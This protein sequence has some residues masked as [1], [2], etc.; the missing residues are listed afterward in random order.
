MVSLVAKIEYCIIN[1]NWM[2]EILAGQKKTLRYSEV[3]PWFPKY[4]IGWIGIGKC[5]QETPNIYECTSVSRPFPII[6]FCWVWCCTHPKGHNIDSN[7]KQANQY[8]SCFETNSL[9]SIEA[10]ESLRE[11]LWNCTIVGH[12][13][14]CIGQFDNRNSNLLTC[15][16]MWHSNR[17]SL[18]YFICK[19]VMLRLFLFNHV[20]I[21]LLTYN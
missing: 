15:L 5:D 17:L 16:I 13:T 12:A 4:Y 8:P 6:T 7:F 14:A 10:V 20:F 18:D 9:W 2:Q 19:K 21:I 1:S 11:E 3:T